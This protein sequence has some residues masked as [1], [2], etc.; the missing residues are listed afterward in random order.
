MAITREIGDRRGEGNAL[1]NMGLAYEVIDDRDQAVRCL[2]MA[3][4]IYV[5]IESPEAEKARSNLTR[6]RGEG[7]EDG[8]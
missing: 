8:G 2:E 5:A 6:L 4:E 3:L 7:G 1:N